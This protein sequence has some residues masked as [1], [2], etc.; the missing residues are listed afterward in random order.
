[1]IM[2]LAT[3]K[4]HAG[5]AFKVWNADQ[6]CGTRYAMDVSFRNRLSQTLR[7]VKASKSRGARL[8]VGL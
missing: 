2:Q 8:L 6:A 4:K 3:Y 7:L 1:M 5:E